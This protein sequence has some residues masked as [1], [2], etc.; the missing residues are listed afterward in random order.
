VF[1]HVTH[2]DEVVAE[3]IAHVRAGVEAAHAG[4][5]EH[6]LLPH[7]GDFVAVEFPLRPD[8]VE[9]LEQVAVGAADV[10]KLAGRGKVDQAQQIFEQ[11]FRACAAAE[12]R[13]E[14][15]R[16]R[17]R[18]LVIDAVALVDA[19]GSAARTHRPGDSRRDRLHVGWNEAERP[20]R[21]VH[22]LEPRRIADV[23]G[24]HGEFLDDATD[25]GRRG[26]RVAWMER[27]SA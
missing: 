4:Q 21:G 14:Q 22:R 26:S 18:C 12:R 15:T 25:S 8:A 5:R 24:R 16:L 11:D 7:V 13:I 27:A 9:A 10:E 20:G 19:L 6:F 3:R 23:A 2:C 1:E 17:A